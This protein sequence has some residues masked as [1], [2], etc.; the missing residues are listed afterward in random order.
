MLLGVGCF[1][2]LQFGLFDGFKCRSI[3]LCSEP[4]LCVCAMQA[5]RAKQRA[6][7]TTV[8]DMLK[9]WAPNGE[10]VVIGYGS[11]RWSPSAPGRI[12]QSRNVNYHALIVLY[13]TGR[14]SSPVKLLYNALKM[15]ERQGRCVVLDISEQRSSSVSL[16]P[17]PPPS[18]SFPLFL[19][20]WCN[21]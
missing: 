18:F 9:K 17:L 4:D 6:V 7:A 20:L 19:L 11:A 1:C 5:Y 21:N 8:N 15:A 13:I 14:E 3:G 2:C 16:G 12:T 10:F